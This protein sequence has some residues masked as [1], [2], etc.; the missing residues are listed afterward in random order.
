MHP[1]WSPEVQSGLERRLR[2]RASTVSEGARFAHGVAAWIQHEASPVSGSCPTSWSSAARHQHRPHTAAFGRRRRAPGR[3]RGASHSPIRHGDAR[4]SRRPAR[5]GGARS[6][7]LANDGAAAPRSLVPRVD[8]GW[9]MGG[10][11]IRWRGDGHGH[12]WSITP[13]VHHQDG[14]SRESPGEGVGDGRRSDASRR[15]NV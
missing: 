9:W 6:G 12:G 15:Q 5:G 7:S 8:D 10:A 1:K 14:E 4:S 11:R 13:V 3:A 2:V